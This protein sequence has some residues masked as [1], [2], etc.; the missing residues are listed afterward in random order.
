MSEQKERAGTSDIFAVSKSVESPSTFRA[1][2]QVVRETAAPSSQ[3]FRPGERFGDFIIL[4]KLGTGSFATVYLAQEVTLDR[5]VA[6]K[7]SEKRGLGEGQ[8]LA[9]LEHQNIVQVYAQFTDSASGK[10][11]LCLQYVP[12][13]TLAQVVERLHVCEKHPEQGIDILESIRIASYEAIPFDPGGIRNREI[14]ASCSFAAAVCRIGV[15]MAEAL[16]FAHGRSVLHCDIKPANILVNLYGRPLLADFNVALDAEKSQT[17]KGVGGTIGYMAPEQLAFLLNQSNNQRIDKR[18]DLYS[19]GV[20]LF[21]FLTGRLPFEVPDN[22]NT[23]ERMLESLQNQQTFS[24]TVS[25]D[26]EGLHPVVERIIR[27]CLDPLPDRRY[28]HGGE[29]S[30]ALANAYDILAI[31]KRLPSGGFITA[32]AKWRPILMLVVL[33]LL[34]QMAGSFFN[35]AYNTVE[36]RL[37]PEQ[38]TAFEKIILGYNLLVYPI[39]VF[40]LIRVLIPV[41]RGWQR[42]PELGKMTGA[43]VDELHGQALRLGTW[44][45]ILALS[46][47]LPGG[48]IFPVL[49]DALAGGVSWQ[50]Y[51]QFLL[52]FT[53]SGLIAVIYSHFGIQFVTLRVFCPSFANADSRTANSLASELAKASR[54]LVPFQSLAAVVP[55]VGAVLLVAFSGEMTLSYRLLVTSLIVLGMI[56]VGI[57]F[58][59]TRQ[60]THL[61]RLLGGELLEGNASH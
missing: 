35:I 45:I 19:L 5:R 40:M 20:V 27:R 32:L 36:I 23:K 2:T 56:G 33:T 29:L 31:E 28:Q 6:L 22:D 24:T 16:E 51:L 11:C 26:S 41:E 18:S 43:E 48:L 53:L 3:R 50:I 39:C 55:L 34:P 21:E 17:G 1:P 52:S 14:I 7:I 25:W 38:H 61:V 46:G 59:V 54:W 4:R 49:I 10:H 15:Q 57:A 30:R 58:A 60:L 44:G 12:G 8:A 47:W 13:T 9:E 42:L 37:S